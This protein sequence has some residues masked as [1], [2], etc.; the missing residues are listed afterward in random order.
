MEYSTSQEVKF[1]WL[2]NE[3]SRFITVTSHCR[4]L[5]GVDF[6]IQIS[7]QYDAKIENVYI[8]VCGPQDVLLGIKKTEKIGFAGLSL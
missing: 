1:E 4:L 8:L 5:Q 2:K 3:S 7:P 6:R